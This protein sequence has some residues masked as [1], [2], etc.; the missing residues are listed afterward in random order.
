MRDSGCCRK[1]CESEMN[2][3]ARNILKALLKLYECDRYQTG[4]QIY[5][6]PKCYP[7][8]IKIVFVD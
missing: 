5:L 8:P 4:N 1:G 6:I 3:R 7:K 2:N